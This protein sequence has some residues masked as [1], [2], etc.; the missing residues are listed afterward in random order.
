MNKKKELETAVEMLKRTVDEIQDALLRENH[1]CPGLIVTA[2][3]GVVFTKY[4]KALKDMG[5]PKYRNVLDTAMR[6]MMT[7]EYGVN[8]PLPEEGQE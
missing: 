1:P 3:M 8:A 5:V 4:L 7:M 2:A 6:R